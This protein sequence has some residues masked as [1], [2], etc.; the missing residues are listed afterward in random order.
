[1]NKI[2]LTIILVFMTVQVFGYFEYFSENPAAIGDRTYG[3]IILPGFDFR[4]GFS[5]NSLKMSDL[6]MFEKGHL[7]T[8]G[9]KA[10]LAGSDLSF[11]GY[12]RV[13]LLGLGFRNWEFSINNHT[14]G[15]LGNIDKEFLEM[16]LYGNEEEGYMQS[17]I[18]DSYFYNFIKGKF[19]WTYPR[20]LNLS[21]IPS[22][23]L[24]DKNSSGF[25]YTLENILNYCLEMNIYL[26][27]NINF[28]N[29]NGYGKVLESTQE[30]VSCADSLYY[31]YDL[32]VI[33][34]DPDMQ[35]INSGLSWGFGLGMK[36]ELPGGW[37]HFGVDDIGSTFHYDGLVRGHYTHYYIDY[38]DLFNEDY[39]PI[40]EGNEIDDEPYP[41]GADEKI[42]PT[43]VIGAEYK[44]LE[45][46]Q[47]MA[48]YLSC[49]YR[50]D[51]FFLSSTYRPLSWTPLRLTYGVGEI[52][53]YKFDFGFD[54]ESFEILM[55]F[56]SYDGVF[57]GAK[58]YGADFGIRFK[59]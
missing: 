46:V 9:E 25:V 47:V 30:L 12:G 20:G 23:R 50:N 15:Y 55:G 8:D 59:F 54:T 4:G 2:I 48:K 36:L 29:A 24:A 31:R 56:I 10:K 13:N 17:A 3:D 45:K 53:S 11:S 41:D 22:V 26:G 19:N 5:N 37:F 27:G 38:L 6:S 32:D 49:D 14:K 28:Y 1:M 44:V 51:G 42:N 39:E 7:L 52:D 43:L 35:D 33:Y 18:S 16:A 34:T 58:G 21:F 57:N 40:D